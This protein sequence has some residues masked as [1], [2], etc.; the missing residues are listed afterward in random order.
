M[1]PEKASR[2]DIDGIMEIVDDAKAY[3]RSRGIHQWQNGYPNP[4][5]IAGDIENG[6]GYLLRDEKGPAAYASISFG[7]EPTYAVIE[8]GSWRSGEPFAVMHRVCVKSGYKGRGTAS[9]FLEKAAR[10]CR[11]RN[12]HWLRMDTHRDNLS[13]QRFLLKNGF[14]YRGIIHLENGDPRLAYDRFVP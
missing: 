11:E 2:A 8:E 3:F 10:L 6:C 7:G 9:L 1:Q 4:D 12:I 5:S 14:Q 13:M